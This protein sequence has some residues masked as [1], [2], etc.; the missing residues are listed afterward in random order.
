MTLYWYGGTGNWSDY[1]NHWSLTL[2]DRAANPASAVP[3]SIDDV[4]ID[5]ASGLSGGTITIP[6]FAYTAYANNFVS[7]TGF[8][9]V[10]TTEQNRLNV[11]GSLTLESGLTITSID[12]GHVRLQSA[13]AGNTIT[14]NGATLNVAQFD[15]YGTGE[16]TLQDNLVTSGSIDH[17]N[18]TFDA[19][20]HNVTA[21]DFYFYA[22]TGYTPTVIMGSG[23]WEATGG[24]WYVD[25]YSGE[26]L[27]VTPETSTIKMSGGGNFYTSNKTYNNL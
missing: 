26:V 17:E 6:G 1:T 2:A 27:T 8:S 13:S 9:Y 11:Y 4:F 18:G 14:I 15:I 20:D 10:I 22:D 7:T 25:E 16:W 5:S 24:D 12:N 21:N 23:T 19:N 3:T